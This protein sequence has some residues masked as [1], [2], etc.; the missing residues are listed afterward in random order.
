MDE[1]KFIDGIAYV[2]LSQ[3][4]G[5]IDWQIGRTKDMDQESIAVRAG[6]FTLNNT[7]DW[8]INSVDTQQ[9]MEAFKPSANQEAQ[10]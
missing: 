8:I 7:K 3:I 10:G 4:V 6:V 2:P 5:I 9:R 1:I